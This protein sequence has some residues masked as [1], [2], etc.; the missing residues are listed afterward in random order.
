MKIHKRT[1]AILLFN[2]V[3]L[4]D[5]AGPYEVFSSA[6][7]LHDDHDRLLDVLTV[8]EHA[9][10]I[11]CRNG[12]TVV[13][14]YTLGTCPPTDILLIPGGYG[15]TQIVERSEIITWIRERAANVELLTSVCTGSFA[16]AKVGL[17]AG[18]PVTTHWE[19]IATLREAYPALDVR[20]DV[21]WVEDG[22]IITSAGV[23]AGI[24]MALHIVARLYG[25]DVARA[26]AIGIEYDAWE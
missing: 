13:P 14:D 17:P 20:E 8:A 7:S 6:R 22:A 21:R 23:S 9:D 16:L 5:F 12:L 19:S 26:T 4:L 2:D 15:V 25:N 24:D 18:T 1:V 10:P 11:H 3:E